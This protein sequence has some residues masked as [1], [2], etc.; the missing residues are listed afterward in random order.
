MS[1]S[2]LPY[3]PVDGGDD[4]GEVSWTAMGEKGGAAS[5]SDGAGSNQMAGRWTERAAAFCGLSTASGLPS[6]TGVR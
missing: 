4:V 1:T 2:I 3:R 6:G 5:Y